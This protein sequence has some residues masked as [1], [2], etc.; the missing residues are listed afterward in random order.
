MSGKK[1]NKRVPKTQKEL[2]KSFKNKSKSKLG[3]K[4]N[5][6][7]N[8]EVDLSTTQ[9]CKCQCCQVAMPQI[10]YSEFVQIATTMWDSADNDSK[11]RFL[12]TSWEYFFRSEFE[13]WG[14]STLIKPCMFLG[15]DGLCTIYDNRPLSCRMF[16]LWPDDVYEERVK[17][18]E[19]S[20]A[21]YGL[22]REDIPLSKQCG[23][24]KR[25]NVDLELT[26]EIIDRLYAK[27]DNLDK[28]VGDFT[29][30]QIEQKENYRTFHDW[31]LLKVFGDDWLSDMTAFM[32]AAS[33][34]VMEEMVITLEEVVTNMVTSGKLKNFKENL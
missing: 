29:E 22:S 24:V 18:F 31:L 5:Q 10:N 6:I 3:D 16:G 32:L 27:L 19:A 12:I 4:L 25:K 20:Y 17:R 33:R 1:T 11:I 21:E 34:E 13:K 8:E 7:Y 28:S 30:L 9:T 14:I 26:E 15:E 2:I 23:E